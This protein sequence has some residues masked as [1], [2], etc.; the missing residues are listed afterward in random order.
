MPGQSLVPLGRRR[1]RLS[2]RGGLRRGACCGLRAETSG[3]LRGKTS[4][5]LGVGVLGVEGVAEGLDVQASV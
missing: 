4:G 1:V 3:R 5:G 2:A